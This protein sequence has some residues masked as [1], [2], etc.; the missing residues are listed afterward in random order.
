MHGSDEEKN[1][2]ITYI[3]F[4]NNAHMDFVEKL[5]DLIT[6]ETVH[7]DSLLLAYGALAAS[8]SSRVQ[9]RIVLFLKRTL[10]QQMELNDTTNTVHLLHALGNTGSKLIVNLLFDYLAHSDSMEIKLAAIGAMRKLTAQEPVQEAFVAILES[11]PQECFVEAIAETL[12]TG[13]EHSNV[14]GTHIDENPRLLNALVT[15]SLRFS[16]NT[17][18]HHLVHSYLE[19]VNTA[20]S[21]RLGKLLEQPVSNRVRRSSTSDWDASNSVYNLVSPLSSRRNDVTFYPTH[22]AYLWGTTFGPSKVNIQVAAGTFG[23][24]RDR[25]NFKV[26]AKAAAKGNLFSRSA[27]IAEA[28]AEILYKNDAFRLKL[29]SRILGIVLLNRE[30]TTTSCCLRQTFPLYSSRYRIIDFLYSVYV[31]VTSISFFAK[32]NTRLSVN[33][34]WDVCSISSA[35]TDVYNLLHGSISL[36][37]TVNAVPE[38][39]ASLTF[40]VWKLLAD[41]PKTKDLFF[42]NFTN[43]S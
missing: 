7:T 27:T 12:F 6:K 8:T 18:L 37:F 28:S 10:I 19:L 5:E 41:L 3:A 2:I 31:Y 9:Q 33:I 40:L 14:M 23:G 30:H 21:H 32:L 16:N 22:K 13:Q 24:F 25:R 39:G 1:S 15:S 34:T 42:L 38:G 20:E 17:E 35:N 43:Y 36:G 29:Y 11:N 4:T 26:F